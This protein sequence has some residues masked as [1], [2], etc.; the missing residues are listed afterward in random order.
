MHA[1]FSIVH[2]FIGGPPPHT[3]G[4][5]HPSTV[6]VRTEQQRPR[7]PRS[8]RFGD[9]HGTNVCVLPVDTGKCAKWALGRQRVFGTS[10]ILLC[11]WQSP[12]TC[13]VVV[14]VVGAQA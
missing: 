9:E 5:V 3:S 12:A 11:C 13:R 10:F 8:V 1:S 6:Y 2:L 14:V 7:P 4:L